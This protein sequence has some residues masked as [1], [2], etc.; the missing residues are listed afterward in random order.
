VVLIPFSECPTISPSERWKFDREL[1]RAME[2]AHKA[3]F[4]LIKM[5][6]ELL[7]EGGMEIFESVLNKVSSIGNLNQRLYISY[8]LL[9]FATFEVICDII[10]C[11]L[12]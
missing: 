5:K 7:S 11:I 9:L 1:S 6:M 8:A 4:L 12:Y 2:D 10:F 3:S